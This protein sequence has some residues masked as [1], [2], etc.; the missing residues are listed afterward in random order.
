M[1][2]YLRSLEKSTINQWYGEQVVGLNN[3][4]KVTGKLLK[5]VKLDG[6]FTKHSPRRSGTN[7]LFQGGVDKKLIKEFAGH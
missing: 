7:R 3:L 2:F 4:R 6:F 5:S 1:D